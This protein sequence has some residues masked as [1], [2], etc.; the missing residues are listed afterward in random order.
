MHMCKMCE[1]TNTYF[2]LAVVKQD[3]RVCLFFLLFFL[4]LYLMNVCVC[5]S[6]SASSTQLTLL[7]NYM[8]IMWAGGHVM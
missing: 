6:V 7:S 4:K 3:E 5:V 8:N 1:H 2:L